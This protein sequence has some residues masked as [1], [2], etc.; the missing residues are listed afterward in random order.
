MQS[1]LPVKGWQIP[2]DEI[3]KRLDLRHGH[4]LV[5]SVDPPGC[6]DIDDALHAR[7]L[8]AEEWGDALGG[9]M[10]PSSAGGRVRRAACVS[11]RRA[12]PSAAAAAEWIALPRVLLHRVEG[13]CGLVT[14][15]CRVPRSSSRSA[16]T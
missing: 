1:C 6:V 3:A 7:E 4:A 10:Q 11:L 5:C 15:E 14:V 13:L 8:P 16:C 2:E 9:G 12:E